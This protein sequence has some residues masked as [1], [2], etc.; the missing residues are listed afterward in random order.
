MSAVTTVRVTEKHI[1][2]GHPDNA[3]ACAFALAVFEALAVEGKAVRNIHVGAP[4]TMGDP[5]TEWRV[6]VTLYDGPYPITAGLD[7]EAV[8]WIVLFDNSQP[9]EPFETT[10]TWE[11]ES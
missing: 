9:T 7:R 1:A 6:R 3:C 11:N 5:Y 8:D 2:E 10:L 4:G